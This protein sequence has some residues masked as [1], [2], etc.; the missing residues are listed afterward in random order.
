LSF[1]SERWLRT[2]Y[3][4]HDGELVLHRRH[5]EVCVFTYLAAELKSGDVSVAGSEEY[6]D[7]R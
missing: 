2:I 4:T 3:G 5:F 6:A 7:Y 1:V